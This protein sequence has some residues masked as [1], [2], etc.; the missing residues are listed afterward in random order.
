MYYHLKFDVGSFKKF[1]QF[2][3]QTENSHKSLFGVCVSYRENVDGRDFLGVVVDTNLAQWRIYTLTSVA[4]RLGI[5]I[6]DM[7]ELTAKEV[8]D[9]YSTKT[10]VRASEVFNECS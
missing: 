10:L 1:K 3:E 8:A 9:I 6:V 5:G 7:R 2:V 4:T